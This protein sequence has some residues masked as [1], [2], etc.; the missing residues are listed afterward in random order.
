MV[1]ARGIVYNPTFVAAITVLYAREVLGEN[2]Q[3]K[4]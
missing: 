1:G 3:R 4:T 2:R